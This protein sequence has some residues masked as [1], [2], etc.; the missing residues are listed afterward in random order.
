[1]YSLGVNL[2][3]DRSAC[4][5][6]SG[7]RMVA[8]AEERLDRVKHS[9]PQDAWGRWFTSVP[10]RSV[11]YCLD[12]AGITLDDL[13]A[14]VFTNAVVLDGTVVRNLTISDCQWQLPWPLRSRWEVLDHHRAHAYSAFFP[15]SFEDAAVVV[16][17]KGG[18]VV[19]EHGDGQPDNRFPVLERA[20]VYRASREKGL[21]L[22]TAVA[23]R[24]TAPYLNCN[25]L[26]A[27]YEAATLAIGY[28]PFDAGKTMGLAPYGDRRH[29]DRM[30]RLVELT[31]DGWWIDW[32]AQSVGREMAPDLWLA[33]F[34][35]SGGSPADP[36]DNDRAIARAA[37]EVVERTMSHLTRMAR[38]RT[39]LP[40]LCLAGGVA[41]NSVANSRIRIESGFEDVWVQPASSDDGTALGAAL[42]GWHSVVGRW[43][44]V[45]RGTR[46]GRSYSIRET[47]A[48]VALAV[49]AGAVARSEVPMCEVARRIADGRIVGWF[50]GRSEFGPRALGSRSILADPRGADTKDLLNRRVKRRESYR[51]Y[52]ASVLLE[53][54]ADWFDCSFDSPYML[55]VVPVRRH[56]RPQVP[57]VTH[58]DGTC[59]IQTLAPDRDGIYYTL[60]S[61]FARITGVP[62]VLNTSFNV[63]GEPIVES[64]IDAVRTFLATEMDDL[65]LDGTILTKPAF[66][67]DSAGFGRHT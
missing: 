14:V 48:A 8:I 17:D 7:G 11:Q 31:G 59:R 38:E 24:P 67:P 39:G 41:L 23:D 16:V 53:R 40:N 45:E 12:S 15:S 42:Y 63:N 1:M 44:D 5:I 64:P 18:S 47:E 20:S 49:A 43:P 10:V 34:G 25:S 30:S 51:P 32:L 2:S 65:Y 66:A 26:G 29:V 4:L 35:A 61:E 9:C 3:H 22:V 28:T 55:F 52:G 46:L 58:V 60:V 56:A 54:C 19:T 13:D 6:G 37:Q 57:A 33:W 27:L 21:E 62:M 50:T 36:G